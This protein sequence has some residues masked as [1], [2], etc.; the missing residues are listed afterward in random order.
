[1]TRQRKIIHVDMDCFY[2]AVEM[3]DDPR[4]LGKPVA[5]GGVERGVLCTANY[6]AR[7]FGVRSA[8]PS[9]EAYR[10][11]PDLTIIPPNF[12]KYRD[13]SQGIHEIFHR[14]TDII[15]PLSLDEA[16]LDVSECDAHGGS[17]TKV[18]KAIRKEIESKYSLTA[19]AG[20]AGNKFLAKVASDWRK[21]NG[22]FT[23][24]PDAVPDFVRH[25]PIDKLWGV[26]KVTANKL[27]VMNVFTCGDCQRLPLTE[28]MERFGKF[29]VTLYNLCRG[30]DERE[31]VSE[32]T[33]KSQSV[34]HTFYEPL[35]HEQCL[36]KLPELL[37]ELT[38]RLAKRDEV[39]AKLFI[40][41]KFSNFEQTTVETL[42]ETVD[43][44]LAR[45]LITE[46]LSRVALPVRLLG[47]GVRYHLEENV[48]ATLF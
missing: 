13:V 15:E 36:A 22:Q 3:R 43:A 27:K 42:S 5:V 30:I 1:M 17:A 33:R 4:L 6:E 9:N 38:S 32:R 35:T 21:P 47:I 28:L 37:E 46:G 7:E 44:T 14:Y 12:S 40:K 31:V 26:G 20:I 8:M 2:A 39:M 11:C 10:L 16:Y 48:Q 23:V 24:V 19:S 34:E 18:A 41:I 25:L 45:T 29:G